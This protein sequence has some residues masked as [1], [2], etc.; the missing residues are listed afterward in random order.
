MQNVTLSNSP[1]LSVAM[2]TTYSNLSKRTKPSDIV[3]ALIFINLHKFHFAD[4]L[5]KEVRD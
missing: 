1:Y 3:E 4:P 2:D 5:S